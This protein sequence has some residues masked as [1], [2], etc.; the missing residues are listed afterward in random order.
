M[1]GLP[2]ITSLKCSKLD[3]PNWSAR[4][5]VFEHMCLRARTRSKKLLFSELVLLCVMFNNNN[6]NYFA[7][8][9]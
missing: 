4:A 1:A 8:I 3:R 7:V 5:R 2:G 6:S 9:S